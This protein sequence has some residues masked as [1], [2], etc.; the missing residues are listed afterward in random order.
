MF[1]LSIDSVFCVTE[2]TPDGA[3]NAGMVIAKLSTQI[4]IATCTGE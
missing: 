4:E 3:Y 1:R 2:M